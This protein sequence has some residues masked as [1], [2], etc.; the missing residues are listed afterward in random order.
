MNMKMIEIM[1]AVRVPLEINAK[2]GDKVL[3]ITDT[4]I[5]PEVWTAMAAAANELGIEP[6]VAIMNPR[7][8]HGYNPTTPIVNA[9]RDPELNL[10]I[11]MTSTAMAHTTL[12][13]EI[14]QSGKAFIL[15]E[16]VTTDML[17]QGGPAYADYTAMGILG[18]KVADLFTKGSRVRVQSDL[19]TD[20]TASIIGRP[21]RN[22]AG[23][24]P[25]MS[26]SGGGGCAFPD[27]EVHVCPVEGTGEGVIVFDTTAHSVGRL[28][29]PIRL[30]VEKGMVTK[31][32]GGLEAEIWR[33]T[34]NK[35]GDPNSYNCPAEIAIGTNP[36]VQV[37]GSMRT[38]KKLYGATH[39]GVGDSIVIGGTCK[40]KLRLEGVIRQPKITVDDQVVAEGGKIFG[41]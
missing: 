22:V 39:I 18:N 1:K 31:I 17:L 13:E 21:G 23:K 27:G 5:E 41:N 20:L 10:I 26:E 34:F 12:S 35:Y 30:T 19:G 36:N 3:I 14:I 9:A 7:M 37:T 6:S 28:K 2:P 40:A 25:I 29:E 15:M 4:R 16:E 33:Q 32:E 11:Y 38:D 24:V 8:S